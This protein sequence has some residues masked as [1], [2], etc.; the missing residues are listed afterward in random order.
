MAQ[1]GMYYLFNRTLILEIEKHWV[2]MHNKHEAFSA[3]L[4][5]LFYLVRKC[6]FVAL[7]FLYLTLQVI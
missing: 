4:N 1:N 7:R 3:K 2:T 6:L 5:A